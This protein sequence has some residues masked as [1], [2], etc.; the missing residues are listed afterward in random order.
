MRA[1]PPSLFSK[2]V[3]LP[4]MQMSKNTFPRSAGRR[5]GFEF[6]SSLPG[7]KNGKFC[8]LFLRNDDLHHVHPAQGWWA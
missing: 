8:W 3:F 5:S 6:L 4:N 1:N 2:V 7:L